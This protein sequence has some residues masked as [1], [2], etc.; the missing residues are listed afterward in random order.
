[1]TK[2]DRRAA[3]KQR[4]AEAKAARVH[5][6]IW[7]EPHEEPVMVRCDSCGFV[8]VNGHARLPWVLVVPC[9]CGSD[10]AVYA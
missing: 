9:V 6:T 1:M 3:K 5:A 2:A 4:H 8:Q 10:T 7:P